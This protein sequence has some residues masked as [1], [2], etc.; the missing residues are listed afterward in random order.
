MDPSG[1]MQNMA[2]MREGNDI[3]DLE[4]KRDDLVILLGWVV[5]RANDLKVQIED[6]TREIDTETR[7]RG[8]TKN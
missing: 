1:T 7:H 4:K 2:G 3:D 6:L 8:R 5:N